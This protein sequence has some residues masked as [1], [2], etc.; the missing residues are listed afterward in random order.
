MVS[1]GENRFE[2]SFK[3]SVLQTQGRRA[4]ARGCRAVGTVRIP[5]RGRADMLGEML[6][7]TVPP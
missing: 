3:A 4:R 1:G 5:G 7:P 6:A 2:A